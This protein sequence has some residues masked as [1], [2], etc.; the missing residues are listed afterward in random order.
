MTLQKW[1]NL[2]PQFFGHFLYFNIKVFKTFDFWKFNPAN[3]LFWQLI[4][5]VLWDIWFHNLGGS[6]GDD[7]GF[8]PDGVVQAVVNDGCVFARFYAVVA[9]DVNL[10]YS[11]LLH[12]NH[13]RY[14]HPPIK[15][16][17]IYKTHIVL[18]FQ[19]HFQLVLPGSIFFKIVYDW[20]VF[21]Y[22]FFNHFS[23]LLF[24]NIFSLTKRP[25]RS[26]SIF[27]LVLVRLYPFSKQ[28]PPLFRS[29][30]FF[31]F[32]FIKRLVNFHPIIFNRFHLDNVPLHEA[33]CQQDV[34]VIRCELIACDFWA[35]KSVFYFFDIFQICN[36]YEIFITRF[37]LV[38]K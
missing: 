11:Q 5:F 17:R 26:H 28:I 3:F 1:V 7:Y 8:E 33:P 34:V 37:S 23:H 29:H 27:Y 38:E 9:V 32:V 25:Y 2:I 22:F 14:R 24:Y 36:F 6:H 19:I 21:I 35:K 4:E 18:H 31:I 30:F 20:S 16:W 15:I 10:L 12:V 13:T